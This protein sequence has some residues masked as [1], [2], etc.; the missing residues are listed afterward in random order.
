MLETGANA[1]MVVRQV[2]QQ[3]KQQYVVDS[4][5]GMQK[6]GERQ[7]ERLIPFIAPVIKRVDM[8]ASLIEV[9]WGADF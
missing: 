9:D 3:D 8:A 1:V 6:K 4:G 5:Q 7:Y 2:V